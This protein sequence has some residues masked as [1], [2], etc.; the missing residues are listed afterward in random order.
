MCTCGEI[1]PHVIMTR[2]DAT[3][4]DVCL[5]DDGAITGALGIGI[6]GVPVSRPKTA[7]QIHRAR[8]TGILMLGDVCLYDRDELPALYVAARAAAKIDQMPGTMRRIL[9]EQGSRRPS[10]PW[11][12]E[13]TDARGNVTERSCRLPR[14]WWPGIVIF[15][16]CGSVGSARGRYQ[17]WRDEKRDGTCTPTGFNFATLAELWTYLDGIK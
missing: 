6:R 8:S 9:R 2:R 5:W 7:E 17:V 1:K 16:F 10:L 15:D 11:R 14:M 3:G 12:T 13:R 4:F